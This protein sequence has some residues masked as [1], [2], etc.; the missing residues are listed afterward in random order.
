MTPRVPKFLLLLALAAVASI[1][2]ASCRFD[3]IILSKPDT[4]VV[5]R[6]DS[7]GIPHTDTLIM[8][9]V[10]TIKTNPRI[11]TVVLHKVDTVFRTRVD[12]V[13]TTRIDTVFK[14]LPGRVDTLYVTRIDTVYQPLPPRVDTLYITHTDTVY[15]QLPPRVD[16]VT[17]VRV[18]TVT[19][20]KTDTLYL[21]LVRVDT[22]WRHDTS[23]VPIYRTDTLWRY[24]TT[25]KT[26]VD[27]LYL[28]GRIVHDTTWVYLQQ[29]PTNPLGGGDPRAGLA[30]IDDIYWQSLVFWH[31]NFM[32]TVVGNLGTGG[33]GSTYD[34]FI[35]VPPGGQMLWRGT[36]NTKM[37]AIQALVPIVITIPSGP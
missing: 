9:R 22:L 10:D 7:I 34:A 11:D 20:L 25:Y 29:H 16:T 31:G 24:D 1:P 26:T 21:T 8:T 27:T 3:R 23:Y 12:T 17:V 4:V 15:K 36:F 13:I 33:R 28:P 35:Y 14:Q 6:V 30:W 32:G 19:K 37:E 18:D 2:I 5:T